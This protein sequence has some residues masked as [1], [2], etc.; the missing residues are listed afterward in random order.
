MRCSAIKT[1]PSFNFQVAVKIK[2]SPI[3]QFSEIF[4]FFLISSIAS[5]L[6]LFHLFI[7]SFTVILSVV[8][9]STNRSRGFSSLSANDSSKVEGERVK[10]LKLSPLLALKFECK[11]FSSNKRWTTNDNVDNK[12]NDWDTEKSGSRVE[13]VKT[14]KIKRK[15]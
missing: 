7:H 15:K 14:K 2:L 4:H 8:E 3:K 9:L 13:L 11:Y 10:L 5:S 1:S 6:N 12:K